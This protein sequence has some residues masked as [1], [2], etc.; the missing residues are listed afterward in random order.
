[1]HEFLWEAYQ[2]VKLLTPRVNILSTWVD[3]G[4][5]FPQVVVPIHTPDQSAWKSLLLLILANPWYVS[6]F[7]LCWCGGCI[8]T[9]YWLLFALLWLLMR[10]SAFSFFSAHLDI[11]FCEVLVQEFCPFF[12]WVDIFFLLICVGVLKNILMIVLLLVIYSITNI[13]SPSVT[14]LSIFF[15]MYLSYIPLSCIPYHKRN[16]NFKIVKF[17]QSFFWWCVN[18]GL[19]YFLFWILFYFF[20]QQVLINYLFYTY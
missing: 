12:C 2:E 20:I 15:I 3:D 9:S 4:K 5:L 17:Y 11:L 10:L 18:V 7:K 13:F 16:L 14:Y 6:H 1:M 19:F 8:M